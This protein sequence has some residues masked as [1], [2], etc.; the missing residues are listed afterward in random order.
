MPSAGKS[1]ARS[2]EVCAQGA[3]VEKPR[4]VN[5][6]TELSVAFEKNTEKVQIHR[7][8]P[9]PDDPATIDDEL[10]AAL[11]KVREGKGPSSSEDDW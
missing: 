9:R 3:R 6:V 7:A 11:R 8:E 2:G 1:A 5:K 10:R 4:V